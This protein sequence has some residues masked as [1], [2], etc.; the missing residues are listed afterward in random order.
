MSIIQSAVATEA[1]AVDG[2]IDVVLRIDDGASLPAASTLYSA[3]RGDGSGGVVQV[4][5]TAGGAID[6]LSVVAKGSGYTY[7]SVDLSNG[8]CFGQPNLT[9]PV[10]TT[11]QRSHLEV[12]LPPRGGHGSDMELELN[13]KRVMTNIRLT[14]AEGSGDFPVDNDFRRIGIIKDPI[15]SASSQFATSSTLS[16]LFS[17][18]ITGTGGTDYIADE[19]ITQTVN[20]GANTAYG[21]VVSWVLD[22]GST[23]DGILK[24]YQSPSQ[25]IDSDGA[26][27]AFEANGAQAV[28]GADS[29]AAGSPDT[30][31]NSVVEGVQLTNGLASPEIDNNSGD[32]IY[33]ENRRLITRAPDQIEDIKL[34]IEF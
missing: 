8:N 32:I 22:S 15:D 31:N 7:A 6:T 5:T 1:A 19:V 34:V 14:Y 23:T 25:H 26:V 12:V 10:A 16:G 29:Q 28:T 17:I 9:S 4:T 11:G 30:T 21:T 24:Y 13:A 20:S 3:I 33:V 18:K 27:Y 2:E